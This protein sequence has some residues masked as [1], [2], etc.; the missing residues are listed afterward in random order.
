MIGERY[1]GIITNMSDYTYH[2]LGCGAIGS[3]AATQLAR[4]GADKF[5]LYDMDTVEDV[6]IGV[7]HYVNDD[8]GKTKVD[9]LKEHILKINN[10][11]TASTFNELF[12]EYYPQDENEIAILG[13]D[14]MLARMQAVKALCAN[15]KKPNY[16]I[17]GRMG[18]EHYMQFVIKNPTVKKYEKVWYSDEEGSTEPCNAKATSYCSSMSGSF[19]SNAIRKLLTNQPCEEEISFHFPTMMLVKNGRIL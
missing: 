16:I 2:I 18:A 5:A 1:K 12:S 15:N 8:I 3:S 9:A 11:S 6:N 10:K 19:I 13:F 7:S 17:D 4:M 14:N